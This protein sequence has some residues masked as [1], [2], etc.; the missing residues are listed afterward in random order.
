MTARRTPP[1]K[2]LSAGANAS[3]TFEVDYT[4]FARTAQ[5]LDPGTYTGEVT[6]Q[7][8]P[9]QT[10]RLAT[11]ALDFV[12]PDLQVTAPT[13]GDQ[14]PKGTR[15]TITWDSPYMGASETV[16]VE[17]VG[18]A[19]RT[20]AASTPNDGSHAWTVPTSIQ[21]G[22]YRIEISPTKLSSRSTESGP[23]TL[24]NAPPAQPTNQTPA[25]DAA[26]ISDPLVLQASSFSDPNQGDTHQ[27]AQWQIRADQAKSLDP[28]IYGDPT[29]EPAPVW[30]TTE[31]GSGDLTAVRVPQGTLPRRPASRSV[32]VRATP[33]GPRGPSGRVPAQVEAAQ[34]QQVTIT[35]EN[36]TSS[37]AAYRLNLQYGD[38]YITS[39]VQPG[40]T[41]TLNVTTD[42]ARSAPL[43]LERA[44]G[45]EVARGTFEVAPARYWWHV[46]YQDDRGQW[47]A[48]SKETSFCALAQGGAP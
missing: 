18:P 36:P 11:V 4:G 32:T 7:G 14:W 48:W 26:T 21:D 2:T 39:P 13:K 38:D 43:I 41:A 5:K 16:K 12:V 37:S 44:N 25:A 22:Q 30:S 45:Q 17:L 19:T 47:S 31:S 15:H 9:G 6:I 40:Q 20:I 10:S 33:R 35:F 1:P 24:G 27:K 3:V 23:F 42:R 28:P 29:T 46:R 34:C 8:G